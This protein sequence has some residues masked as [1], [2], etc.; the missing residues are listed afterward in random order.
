MTANAPVRVLIVEDSPV[1]R[2]LLV[3]MLG[4]DPR[5]KVIGAVETGE[6]AI[7]VLP[8]LQPDVIS[9][10]IRLP[11]MDGF[12]ATRWIMSNMPTPIV[13]VSADVDDQSLQTSMKALSAGALSVVEKPVGTTHRDYEAVSRHLCTQLAIMS[14]VKVVRQRFS[15][16]DGV[17]TSPQQG[18][19]APRT[20]SLD[21]AGSDY[22]LVGLVASTG[23]PTALHS[24]LMH[25]PANFPVP[26]VV[27]QH[28]GAKFL[29]G[30]ASWLDRTCA[31]S[32]KIADNN[33]VPSPGVVYVAPGDVHLGFDGKR[34]RLE[35]GPSEHGQC[36]SGSVL[37]RSIA[38][39]DGPRGVGVI[40]TGMGEDGADGL[41]ELRLAGGRT[42][43]EDEST[44]VVNGMPGAAVCLGAA[45]DVLPLDRIPGRLVHTVTRLARSA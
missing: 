8:Q 31:L 14:Q 17:E 16:A 12:M 15:P 13:V 34:L 9:M 20:I 6:R 45:E 32:V 42:F 29:A 35:S 44:A 4:Q 5:L 10:D 41:L 27:V 38:R 1:V 7:K 33:E 19:A 25:L 39:A 3:H 43:A 36:P 26:I 2:E 40:L 21:G 24:I 37:L 18:A 28:M 23:G 22:S 11:G 30:F